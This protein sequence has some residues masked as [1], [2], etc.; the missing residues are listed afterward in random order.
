MSGGVVEQG[1][2]P[3]PCALCGNA[4][5]RVLFTVPIDTAPEGR[6][7]IVR[8]ARCGLRRLDPRP[9]DERLSE[10]YTDDYYSYAGR[11]RSALKQRVWDWLRDASSGVRDAP[12]PVRVFATAVARWRFDVN[13]PLAPGARL[14]VLDVGCGYGDL[15]LYFRDRGNDVVGIDL[16]ERA[17][18][19]AARFG[20][21]V[22]PRPLAD[23]A[24]PEAS[25]DVAI[26]QHSLEHLPDP[27]GALAETARVV[28]PG[29][30][31][32]IALPNGDAAGLAYERERWGSLFC[33]GHFW[34]FDA[35]TLQQLLERH[36]F[37][38]TSVGTR[39]IW[40]DHWRLFRYTLSDTSVSRPRRARVALR[41][42]RA[43]AGSLRRGRG[44][45]L[46]VVARL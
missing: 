9:T 5:S 34:F 17:A 4:P 38:V 2:V 28:A 8:C 42:V 46:R 20:I 25:I 24:L 41:A 40:I 21:T 23:V 10:L 43:A 7:L 22:H 1:W 45:V 11:S 44:D 19:A 33:P 16:D 12:P 35:R 39:T 18:Q 36:G 6:G 27:D 3:S 30:E 37:T 31:V 26:Y 14:R 15:L 32:H 29:G 13:V